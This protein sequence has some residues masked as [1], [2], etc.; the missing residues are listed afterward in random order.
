MEARDRI[1]QLDNLVSTD[2][3]KIVGD[4]GD[5]V[6]HR[7]AAG[8]LD[9]DG[10]EEILLNAQAAT[11][12]VARDRLESGLAGVVQLSEVADGAR[13]W[14]LVADD[15][16][17]FPTVV[18][19]L[20]GDGSPSLI[21]GR[22]V[23]NSRDLAR[24][25]AADGAA[26]GT[27]DL[28]N[29]PPL[30]DSLAAPRWWELWTLD[31]IDGDG[32]SDLGA[33][34]PWW[35]GSA[36]A[37]LVTDRSLFDVPEGK[38]EANDFDRADGWTVTGGPR[39]WFLDPVQGDVDAD[40]LADMLLATSPRDGREWRSAIGEI[41]LVLAADLFALDAVDGEADRRLELHNLAGDDDRDGLSN[42]LDSDDDG[43]GWPD[44]VDAF[45]LDAS[46]QRDSDFDGYGNNRD[47][48]PHDGSEH[49][50]TDGDGIGDRADTDDDNDGIADAE[51]DFPYDTDNDGIDNIDDPDDDNDGVVDARDAFP[52]DAAE[53]ADSDGDGVGDNADADD[54]N[55]GVAGRERCLPARR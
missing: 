46:E 13:S 40:G 12:V 24:A 47:A 18:A 29:A 42:T 51:D 43:D 17:A 39:S 35:L 9:G 31:D 6:G 21:A 34:G 49:T 10:Y 19:D 22:Y 36:K 26:D 53:A 44:R 14:E 3:W 54:D 7:V 30:P 28:P 5:R 45:P 1:I 4:A 25:D 48:F 8:D 15:R 23:V 32:T 41:S 38:I 50:D 2:G 20:I 37:H 27:V 55:D 33:R 16:W 11:Y 52:L